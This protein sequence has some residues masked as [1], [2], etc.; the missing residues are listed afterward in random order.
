M[1]GVLR[2]H[3]KGDGW[4]CMYRLRLENIGDLVVRDDLA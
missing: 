2:M 1:P 3:M 4:V